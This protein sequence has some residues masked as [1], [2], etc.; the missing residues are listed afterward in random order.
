MNSLQV[1]SG[2]LLL[3]LL[4]VLHA[5]IHVFLGVKHKAMEEMERKLCRL[6]TEFVESEEKSI[7]FGDGKIW[8]DVEADTWLHFCFCYVSVAPL[9]IL[10]LYSLFAY[11]LPLYRLGDHISTRITFIPSRIF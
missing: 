6:R 5:S 10:L 3:K 11:P 8:K 9:Y 7:V 2:L 4:R 1:Q